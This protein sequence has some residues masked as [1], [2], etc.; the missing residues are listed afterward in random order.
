MCVG[1]LIMSVYV[2]IRLYGASVMS[3]VLARKP[4]PYAIRR[5]HT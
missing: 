2:Q 4:L 5:Y 1:R 3:Y